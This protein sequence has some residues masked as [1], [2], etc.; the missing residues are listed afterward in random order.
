MSIK[1]NTTYGNKGEV[2]PWCLEV[3]DLRLELPYLVGSS[4]QPE[5][6][7]KGE[8]LPSIKGIS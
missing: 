4:D 5:V 1:A 2:G 8:M 3:S 7:T 6:A